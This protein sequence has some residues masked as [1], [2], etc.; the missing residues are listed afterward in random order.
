MVSVSY[1]DFHTIMDLTTALLTAVETEAV[2]DLAIDVLNLYSNA[3]MSNMSGAAG[4]KT[5]TL[6]SGQKGG[7]F[8][9]ARAIYYSFFKDITPSAIGGLSTTPVD[10]LSNPTVERMIVL[11]AKKLTQQYFPGRGFEAAFFQSLNPGL[12]NGLSVI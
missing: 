7:V 3:E 5:V 2:I 6:T 8:M 1:T 4:G 9:A 10:V 12:N 11:A